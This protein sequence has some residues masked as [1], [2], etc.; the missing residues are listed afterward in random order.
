[1][2]NLMQL[3]APNPM[4]ATELGNF[5]AKDIRPLVSI[6]AKGGKGYLTKMIDKL[7][8]MQS[9]SIEQEKRV[10]EMLGV[11][12][13]QELQSELDRMNNEGLFALSNEVLRRMPAIARARDA[14]ISV[15]MI[16]KE[17]EKDFVQYLAGADTQKTI[18]EIAKD[19]TES[20]VTDL[21]TQF[22][23]YEKERLH[24]KKGSLVT[25]VSRTKTKKEVNGLVFGK[26]TKYRKQ[27]LKKQLGMRVDVL[28]VRG[29]G[30]EEELTITINDQDTQLRY[31][32]YF[33]LT[34]E[35]KE[36]LYNDEEIW[37]KFKEAVSSCVGTSLKP[38]VKASMQHMGKKAFIDTG[39]SYAD[40]IGVLGE[41]Q[42]IVFL[43]CL[44]AKKSLAPRFLGHITNEKEEKIGIDVALESI[45]FQIKN[46]N[47]Y[48]SRDTQ[49]EGMM[50]GGEYKLQNFLDLVSE[51][52]SDPGMRW[53]LEQFYAA[54]V[55][56]IQVAGEKG[57][58]FANIRSWMDKIQKDQLPKIYHGA[59][60]ELLPLKQITWVE[61]SVNNDLTRGSGVNAFYIIGG[62]RVLPVSKIL[63]LYIQFLQNLQNDIDSPKLIQM[64]KDHGISYSGK[65]TYQQYFDQEPG[66]FFSGYH[67]IADDITINYNI[68]MNIDYS[69]EEVLSKVVKE[70]VRL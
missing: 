64:R 49:D 48:G 43:G 32:P 12:D 4:T 70:G 11:R 51:N 56:H 45:G 59:I 54:S 7:Q 41:L 25:G 69:I 47:T 30:Y 63:S 42:A 65:E 18:K 34:T 68:N 58:E 2:G 44:G 38:H 8:Q 16:R 35:E 19:M 20:E 13:L 66:Y 29:T 27:Q 37:K 9:S 1:M 3:M 55:Y 24:I 15:D 31:Y 21:L 5:L 26:F 39:G 36:V 53:N 10:Y 61:E 60:G 57:S 46:Y 28:P 33:S 67:A 14:H 40:I 52:F 50:L 62:T 23:K 22:Q 17:I 6:N